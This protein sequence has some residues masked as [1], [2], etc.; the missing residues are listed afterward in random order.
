MTTIS[1]VHIP[2]ELFGRYDRPGPRYTSYP[3]VTAWSTDFGPAAYHDALR[4]VA[5]APADQLSVY[6]HL[7]FCNIRCLYCGCNVSVTHDTAKIDR[8]LDHLEREMDMV[9]GELGRG[10]DVVQLHLGG[11]TPNYLSDVQLARLVGMVE[12]RFRLVP[13]AET[14]IECDPRKA[15]AMQLDVLAGLGFRRISFGVQD[16]DADVQRAIGRLQPVELIRDVYW[17]ARSAGFES[18]NVDLI[19]GLPQQ[20]AESFAATV[21]EVIALAPER[22]ACFGYAHLPGSR[23]HQR[24][25]DEATIPVGRDKLALFHGAVQSFT[26]AGY[27]WIGL[28]HFA[29]ATDELAV[30]LDERRLHRNFMGYTVRPAPHMLAFGMS[31]IGEVGGSF[32]QNDAQLKTWTE[33]VEAGRLPVVRGHRLSPDDVRRREAILHLMCNLELPEA[34]ATGDLQ[35]A[36]ERIARY[37]DDGFV[38][39]RGDRLVVTPLGRYFLRIL[40][41]ELDAYLERDGGRW[42]FSRTI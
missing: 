13:G 30:A 25:L 34:L 42:Q 4:A 2:D 21:E 38:A 15:T 22:V 27:S 24:A 3:P 26:D 17:N 16:L 11:G 37:A 8:Y 35:P 19:Y 14:S 1:P 9:V 12:D 36:Y 28:D 10:R 7:P 6:V 40:C 41:M 33:A 18:V 29:L 32:V 20:T 31:G 23:P 5:A 39:I